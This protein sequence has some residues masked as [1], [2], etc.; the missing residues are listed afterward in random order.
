MKT[1][2]TFKRNQIHNVNGK[3]FDKDSIAVID[4]ETAY[5]GRTRAF[6]LFSDD[7]LDEFTDKTLP[8]DID[9][10]YKRGFILV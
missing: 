1:Y 5:E 6:E 8:K 3:V 2:I 10:Y 4:A 9:E 7:Y